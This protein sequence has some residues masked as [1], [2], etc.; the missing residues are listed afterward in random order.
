[1]ICCN[2]FPIQALAKPR[3]HYGGLSCYSCRAFFRWVNVVVVNA[4]FILIIVT[5]TTITVIITIIILIIMMFMLILI[6]RTSQRADRPVC[7]ESGSCPMKQ[8][9]MMIEMMVVMMTMM[10]AVQAYD[11]NDLC[12]D[13]DD[14]A[15]GEQV[16]DRK[17][18]SACRYSQCLR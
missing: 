4:T 18:C 15:L 16:A 8:V 17:Q 11:D 2:T 13:V 3:Y 7:K 14:D 1:M 9:F 12:Y 5:V 6:R 10:V